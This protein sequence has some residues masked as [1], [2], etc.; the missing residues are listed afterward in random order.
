MAN[1]MGTRELPYTKAMPMDENHLAKLI[2]E[3]MVAFNDFIRKHIFPT[4]IVNV[5]RPDDSGYGH[6]SEFFTRPKFWHALFDYQDEHLNIPEVK[7]L[8]DYLWDNGGHRMTITR[9]DA[10]P[11]QSGW[12]TTAFHI[13]VPASLYN[14]WD[15]HS[16]RSF[17]TTGL[18]S[19]FAVPMEEINQ[20]AKDIASIEVGNGAQIKIT[21]PLLQLTLLDQ[22]SVELEPGVTLHQWTLEDKTVYLHRNSRVYTSFNFH[23]PHMSNCYLAIIANEQQVFGQERNTAILE[24]FVGPIIGR[25]KWA[26]M[27]ATNPMKLICELPITAEMQQSLSGFFPVHRQAIKIARD[28]E[29]ILD[30]NGCQSAAKLLEILKDAVKVYPDLLDVVWMFDRATL[31]VLPRDVLL[32]SAIGLERLL[33]HGSGENTRRF[34]VYGAA[35]TGGNPI[36][37]EKRLAEIYSL[38]SKA[39]HGSDDKPEKFEKLSATARA[40]LAMVLANVVRL[41]VSSKIIPIGKEKNIN[42]SI[43]RYLTSQ[44]Y[45]AA[46][47]DLNVA[48]K[49]K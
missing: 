35:L 39:A 13:M 6:R 44:M 20:L 42:K 49:H 43:E 36:K 18:W 4:E 30:Q 9:D 32:E 28:G 46:Q 3:A 1:I 15:E 34:K 5:P 19:P 27:L 21:V 12:A 16:I 29:V 22:K 33:V 48:E 31:A 10:D 8:M 23:F 24:K 7:V 14:L 47:N 26:I 25:V 2:Q 45:I 41:V 40:D 38:R 17:F 37:S 11:D